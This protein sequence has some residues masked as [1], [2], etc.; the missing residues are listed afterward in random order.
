[1]WSRESA[2]FKRC[3]EEACHAARL[4]ITALTCCVVP[5]SGGPCSMAG[6]TYVNTT[7]QVCTLDLH[8][9][10]PAQ[11]IEQS[12]TSAT[13]SELKTVCDW[14]V[15][16]CDSCKR[17]T[18]LSITLS[19]ARACLQMLLMDPGASAVFYFQVTQAGPYYGGQGNCQF[20][21]TVTNQVSCMQCS[22]EDAALLAQTCSPHRESHLFWGHGLFTAVHHGVQPIMG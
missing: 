13:H 9:S 8:R 19:M 3:S 11:A 2:H 18:L 21:T 4:R 20:N 17:T 10:L 16:A 15:D 22:S 5:A 12:G 14:R 7:M 1:M 6:F